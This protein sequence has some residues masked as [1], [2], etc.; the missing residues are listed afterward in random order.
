[1][2]EYD[3]MVNAFAASGIVAV[4]SGIVG[5]F[6]VLRGQTFAGH[7]LSHVGFT[8]ATGA[9]LLG[10][11][12]LWGMV[13]FTLAAGVGMGALGE[14]LSGRDVAIGVIL[15][16]SLGFGLLFLHFFTAYATQATALLFGNVLGVSHDTLVVLAGLAVVSLGALA[17]IMRPLLFASLQPEL[18]EAKGVSLRLVSVMFLAITALAVAAC[19]QIVGVL[20]VFALMVGPAAAAQNVTTRLSSGLVLAALFALAQAWVGLT[21]AFYTDWPTSFW[22]TMLAAVVYGASLL[23][24]RGN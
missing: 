9:V 2:F 22:I 15:S 8:G 10:M 17:V 23:G 3:F 7:A 5:Y 18:A 12:P 14:R 19:T 13:G 11:P 16:L 6:L 21:L 24:K 1:M 20:L 4:L